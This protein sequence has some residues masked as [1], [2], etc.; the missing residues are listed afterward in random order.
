MLELKVKKVEEKD[1][2]DKLR[3][4]GLIPAVYYGPKQV[5]TPIKIALNDFMKIYDEAGESTIIELQDGGE[6][7]DVLIKD[8]DYDPVRGHVIHVDFYAIERGKKLEVDVE[9]DFV[10]ESPAEK[11]G[12]QIVKVVYDLKVESLPRDLPSKLVVDMTKLVAVGDQILAKDIVLPEGVEL[13]VEP[14]EPVILVKEAKEEE[15]E[16]APVEVDMDA[17][18]DVNE[19]GKG[20]ESGEEKAEG[21]PAEEKT[22]G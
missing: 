6:N 10:G 12:A 4:Q 13:K 2:P 5:S 17:I 18:E 21:A 22:E 16:E 8:V 20:E 7:H 15:I 1:R 14:E 9:L 11:Q 19:K 3:G